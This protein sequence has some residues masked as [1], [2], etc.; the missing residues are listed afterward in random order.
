MFVK[1]VRAADKNTRPVTAMYECNRYSFVKDPGTTDN[2]YKF[3]L[4][5]RLHE[6]I[7]NTMQFYPNDGDDVFIMNNEG[8]TIDRYTF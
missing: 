5:I 1:I 8:K 2:I 6:R 4:E 3:I 7:D